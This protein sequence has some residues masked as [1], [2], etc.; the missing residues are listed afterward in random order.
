MPVR[1]GRV[2]HGVLIPCAS[3]FHRPLVIRCNRQLR[4][5]HVAK[6]HLCALLGVVPLHGLA[7]TPVKCPVPGLLD[8]LHHRGCY[9]AKNL[10]NSFLKL[11]L[12]K[13]V[14][15][16]QNLSFF[17]KICFFFGQYLSF[18]VNICQILVNICQT[19]FLFVNMLSK[20]VFICL[21]LSNVCLYL[22]LFVFICLYLFLFVFICL[23]F[24]KICQHLA[25]L[26]PKTPSI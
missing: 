23:Y 5:S 19:L 20:S 26:P 9:P 17:V 4:T 10:F 25:E 24:V 8:P 16:C 3:L 18:F 6:R 2:P 1:K 22:S 15:F 12:S 13:F 7:F 14:L 11:I 21:Y